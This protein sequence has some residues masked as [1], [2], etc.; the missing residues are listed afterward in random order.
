[1]VPV[2]WLAS[3]S[4]D[5]ADRVWPNRLTFGTSPDALRQMADLG[6]KGWLDWQL[7]LPASDPVLEERLAAA[8]LRISCV[9]GADEDGK[10]WATPDEMRPLQMLRA[11]PADLVRLLDWGPGKGMDF[12][13]AI[14]AAPIRVV[15]AEAQLPEVM[16]Q[17]WHDHFNVFSGNADSI[18]S[19]A[20]GNH[21]REHLELQS[22][23]ARNH[24][25][26]RY[27]D[28]KDVQGAGAGLAKVVLTWTST[29]SPAPSPAGGSGTCVAWQT[30]KRPGAPGVST[31][32]GVGT[33]PT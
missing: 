16:T 18:A 25:N 4:A 3:R 19:P 27:R 17:F 2:P 9:A 6:R 24:L 31:L 20:N 22:P 7:S 11:D 28:W 14:A 32:S 26:D 10:V 1:V 21:A 29:R 12:S 8:R 13:D 5:A 15:H 23:G 33:T 30:A